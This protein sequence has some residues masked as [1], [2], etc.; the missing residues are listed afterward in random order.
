PGGER[1]LRAGV[2]A[3]RAA[4]ARRPGR[5]ALPH[6]GTAHRRDRSGLATSGAAGALVLAGCAVAG[7]GYGAVQNLTLLVAF[8]RSGPSGSATASTVWNAGFD[9]GTALGAG[10]VGAVA[11]AGAGLPGAVAL[12]AVPVLGV[13]P[14]V[15]RLRAG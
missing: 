12:T 4:R 2:L 5:P 7:T 13:L 3:G 8:S 11:S 9:A 10:A 14:L 15:A 6:P 1:L